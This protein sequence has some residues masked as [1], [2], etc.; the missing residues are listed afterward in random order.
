M[1]LSLNSQRIG[2]SVALHSLDDDDAIVRS[3]PAR[4][5]IVRDISSK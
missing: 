1:A 5:K 3:E 2:S 4:E